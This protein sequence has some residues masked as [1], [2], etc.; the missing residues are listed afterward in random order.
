LE[1]VPGWSQNDKAALRAVVLAKGGQEQSRY[2]HLFDRHQ[3]LR[4]A[5]LKL[6]RRGLKKLE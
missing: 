3:Q 5:L 1:T 2:V 6:S 4:E